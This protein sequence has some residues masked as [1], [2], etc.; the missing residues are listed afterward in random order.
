[1]PAEVHAVPVSEPATVNPASSAA[2]SNPFRHFVD[3]DA[4]TIR[5]R[6]LPLG[7]LVD[8]KLFDP[9]YVDTL[10]SQ[11][12]NAQP[13]RHLVQDGW[14]NPDLLE[15]A[16]EEFAA[17]SAPEWTEWASRHQQI[18]RSPPNQPMGPATTLYFSLVNA[19][20]FVELLSDVMAVPNLIADVSLLSGGLHESRNGG[21]FGIHR[22]F[23]R[24]VHTGLNNEMALMTYLNKDWD[25]AW[26][27]ALEL[28]DKDRKSCVDSIQ[29]EFNRSVVLCHGPSSYHG[30]PHPMQLPEGRT[31]RSLSAYYYSSRLLPQDAK[32]A[33]QSTQ[34]LI[35]KPQERLREMARNVAPPILWNAL[36]RAFGPR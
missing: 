16:S 26:G 23:D 28:W 19:G 17:L 11:V 35:F 15:L 21:R 13:F 12:A 29:P 18:Y 5:G 36:K 4:V 22:D 8:H 34:F 25:P 27:G 3:A 14:F 32:K 6:R 9:A 1:M 20:W 30:H 10:R 2:F 7:D 24:H 31:R 33:P